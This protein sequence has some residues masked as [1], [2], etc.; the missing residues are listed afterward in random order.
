[1]VRL[2]RPDVVRPPHNS[3]Q[4]LARF[5][6]SYLSVPEMYPVDAVRCCQMRFP[7]FV[8]GEDD[9]DDLGGRAPTTLPKQRYQLDGW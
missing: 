4:N 2:Q 8:V 7:R 9:L 6:T 5:R 3:Q 1:M